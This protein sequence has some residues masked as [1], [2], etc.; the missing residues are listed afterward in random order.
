MELKKQYQVPDK[1][2]SFW[3]ASDELHWPWKHSDIQIVSCSTL[4][5]DTGPYHVWELKI[6]GEKGEY[7]DGALLE[8][9]EGQETRVIRVAQPGFVKL[10]LGIGLCNFLWEN[11]FSSLP[12]L[13]NIIDPCLQGHLKTDFC[14][15]G[16]DQLAAVNSTLLI[17]KSTGFMPRADNIIQLRKNDVLVAKAMEYS[18]ILSIN[19]P[20]FIGSNGAVLETAL[21]D[22]DRGASWLFW[23]YYDYF[24]KGIAPSTQRYHVARGSEFCPRI[25]Y[26]IDQR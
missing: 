13:N 24:F 3:N 6:P 14:R 22:Y 21:V 20:Q 15:I 18:V 25:R 7:F 12:E 23:T 10:S 17:N 4:E 8:L 2:M 9:N 1:F 16:L 26:N 11:T 19:S 5:S